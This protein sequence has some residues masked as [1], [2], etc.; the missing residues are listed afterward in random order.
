MGAGTSF[1]GYGAVQ[2]SDLPGD[3]RIALEAQAVP[4]WASMYGIG[5]QY[6]GFR[7]TLFIS[8]QAMSWNQMALVQSY[9][10]TKSYQYPPLLRDIY[11]ASVG[12]S[13]PLDLYDRVELGVTAEQF[14]EVFPLDALGLAERHITYRIFPASLAIVRETTRWH[15]LMPVQGYRI[16]LGASQTVPAGSSSLLLTEYNG[17]S[18]WY[19]GFLE[20]FALATRLWGAASQGRNRRYFFLGGRYSL[21]AFPSGAV[22]GNAAVLWNNELRASLVRHMNIRMPFLPILLTDLQAVGFIDAAAGID[23]SSGMH[24][25]DYRPASV[26]GGLN[27]IG[28][29]FQSQPILFA[30]EVAR[31]I[32]EYQRRPTVYGRL[33]PVF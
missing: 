31:R 5:Y 20:D 21:R 9:L 3:N 32:D 29:M 10:S 7:P 13:Y 19:Y 26:G 11:A 22:M 12:M 2:M 6:S 28:F 24:P 23:T 30:I 8:L 18:Q 16:R 27:I 15:R 25:E 17:E 1:A 33:G 14:T 4:G